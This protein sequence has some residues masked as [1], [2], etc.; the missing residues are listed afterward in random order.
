MKNLYLLVFFLLFLTFPAELLSQNNTLQKYVESLKSRECLKNAI[1]GI[2]VA[3][4]KGYTIASQNPD[5]PLLPASTLKIITTGVALNL[6]G[7]E[8]RF[9]TH[10]GYSGDIVN[11]VLNG[12]IYIIGNGDPTLG[13]PVLPANSVA[14]SVRSADFTVLPPDSLFSCWR[15]AIIKAGIEEIN[16]NIVADDTYFEDEVIPVSWSWGNIGAFYGSGVSGLSFYE[17]FQNIV[18]KRS[19]S[20]SSEII[21]SN[22]FPVVPE[23]R[24]RNNLK[25]LHK[26]VSDS[27][28]YFTSDLAKIGALKG[29]IYM[30]GDSLTISLSNKFPHLS[31][32]YEF[33]E[34][35]F[36]NGMRGSVNVLDYKE[37]ADLNR[38]TDTLYTTFSPPLEWVVNVTNRESNNLYAEALF[39]NIGKSLKGNGSYDSSK[40]ALTEELMKMGIEHND[41]IQ[42]DG[43][44]LSRQNYVTARFLCDYLTSIRY[45]KEFATFYNSL[46]Q[47]GTPGTLEHVLYKADLSLKRRI[48]AKSG[49]LDNVKCYAG[50]VE[51]RSGEL[52]SFAILINNY[53]ANT[54]EIQGV[55]EELMREMLN[56]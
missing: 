25:L 43:S 34:Y 45:T 10:L 1:V 44:G 24:V 37:Y 54:S 2:K 33:K 30:K 27:F 22:L 14:L 52:I 15:G 39:R 35:L 31:C 46:P 6:F 4:S 20:T 12:N 48:R 21:I 53:L 50:Y 16:G 32:A 19:D 40:V 18:L 11:G 36:R 17:N 51:R 49:S 42:S 13:A 28:I 23:M 41:F 5:I 47:P 9:S 29:A 3:D 26:K 38:I 8:Y 55:I 7:K 56:Y